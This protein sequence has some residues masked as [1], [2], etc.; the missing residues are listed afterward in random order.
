MNLKMRAYYV[1]YRGFTL[2]V[3]ACCRRAMGCGPPAFD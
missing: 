2:A 1:R 3:Y